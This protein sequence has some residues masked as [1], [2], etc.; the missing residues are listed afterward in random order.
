MKT[1]GK[2]KMLNITGEKENVAHR[3]IVTEMSA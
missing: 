1:S 2:I 3:Q